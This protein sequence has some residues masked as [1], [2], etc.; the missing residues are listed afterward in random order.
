MNKD[1]GKL[2]ENVSMNQGD[3]EAYLYNARFDN[4]FSTDFY[5]EF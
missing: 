3:M 2:K 4:E 1:L 5:D